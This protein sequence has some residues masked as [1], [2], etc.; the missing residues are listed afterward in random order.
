MLPTP[1]LLITNPFSALYRGRGRKRSE[2]GQDQVI[3]VEGDYVTVDRKVSGKVCSV[4][5]ERYSR[6]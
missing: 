3:W 5:L 4:D 1:G 2:I 6:V